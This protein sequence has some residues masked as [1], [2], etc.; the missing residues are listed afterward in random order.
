MRPYLRARLAL[1]SPCT[2]LLAMLALSG[3]HTLSAAEVK[4]I[5][6]NAAAF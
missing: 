2:V 1:V 4:L 3:C 5:A 6:T